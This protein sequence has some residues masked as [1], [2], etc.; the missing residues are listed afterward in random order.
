LDYSKLSTSEQEA[1][2]WYFELAL[3]QRCN[4]PFSTEKAQEIEQAIK[5][6]LPENKRLEIEEAMQLVVSNA[7]DKIEKTLALA[8]TVAIQKANEYLAALDRQIDIKVNNQLSKMPEAN[9][10]TLLKNSGLDHEVHASELQRALKNIIN[11]RAG[12]VV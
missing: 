11:N 2:S 7:F 3:R 10:A 12:G 9:R 8:E 6:N 1:A 4:L 5:D